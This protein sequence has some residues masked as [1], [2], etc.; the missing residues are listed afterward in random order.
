MKDKLFD[1]LVDVVP[2]NLDE[3]EEELLQALG[4]NEL[5]NIA[6]HCREKGL[7]VPTEIEAL[8]PGKAKH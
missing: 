8:L 4:P 2:L 1:K 5:K 3:P 6:E 7:K